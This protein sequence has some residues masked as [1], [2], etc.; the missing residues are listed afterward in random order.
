MRP[1]AKLL[2]AFTAKI[3]G[4]SGWE[5]LLGEFWEAA[6]DLAR[7]G[8]ISEDTLNRLTIPIGYRSPEDIA[9]SGSELCGLAIERVGGL[10]IPD[11]FWSEYT[12]T[13]DAKRL[14]QRHS[15][16][17]RAWAGPTLQGCIPDGPNRATVIDALFNRFQERLAR[18]PRTHEPNLIA[19]VLTRLLKTSALRNSIEG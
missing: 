5:W 15:D 1:G 4:T 13:G 16:L 6:V 11:P 8:F 7:D 17:T 12:L 10:K 3:D 18:N 2:T 14:A 19:V 9:S